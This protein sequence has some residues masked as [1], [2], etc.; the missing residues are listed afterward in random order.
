ME[1]FRTK[2]AAC[3]AQKSQAVAAT[4]KNGPW[5]GQLSDWRGR[6]EESGRG[7]ENVMNLFI[8]I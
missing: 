3:N 7:E 6:E 5:S 4:S 1:E 2:N 8:Y